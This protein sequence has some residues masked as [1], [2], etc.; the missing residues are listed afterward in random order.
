LAEIHP[1]AAN[2][3]T[4]EEGGG[5]N[6]M[7]DCYYLQDED[8]KVAAQNGI[9]KQTLEQRIRDFAWDKWRAITTPPRPQKSLKEWRKIAEQN[10]IRYPTLQKRMNI[11]GWDPM[12]AATEPLQD[13]KK[14]MAEVAKGRRIY[15]KEQIETA[16]K[17]GIDYHTFWQRVRT[18]WTIKDAITIPTMT[19]SQITRVMKDEFGNATRKLRE[20]F[21]KKG[22]IK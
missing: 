14:A 20:P 12:R 1:D 22:A 10:G 11:L 8:Y 6:K 17:N 18:G 21:V 7:M 3:S 16:E 13:R 5:K 9:C 4:S 2:R 19:R 15:S